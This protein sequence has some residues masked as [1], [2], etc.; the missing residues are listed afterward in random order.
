MPRTRISPS[1]RFLRRVNKSDG[2][3]LWS[4][5]GLSGTGYGQFWHNG[6]NT[7]AHRYAW[8]MH[9]GHIPQ[10]LFVCHRCDNRLCVN[11]SHLFLGTAQD[12]VDDMRAKQR[13]AYGEKQHQ[14]KLTFESAH[15]I[16]MA[17]TMGARISRLAKT[18]SVDR[19]TVADVVRGRQ[20]VSAC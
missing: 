13:D 15:E 19:C 4:G 17:W 6:T 3:W 2:C 18:F 16:R 5:S 14:A 9:H 12:N 8:T 20:W 11:P 1:E 10:G 7:T